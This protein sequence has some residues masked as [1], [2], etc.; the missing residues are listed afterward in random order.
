[1]LP[2][3]VVVTIAGLQLLDTAMNVESWVTVLECA[4]IAVLELEV[5]D[6]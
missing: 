4:E 1:M 3:A 2:A 5:C 6:W